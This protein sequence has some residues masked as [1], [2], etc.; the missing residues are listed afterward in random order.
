ME[1]LDG[2]AEDWLPPFVAEWRAANRAGFRDLAAALRDEI[3]ADRLLIGTQL[4]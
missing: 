1:R 3:A 2:R 4:P